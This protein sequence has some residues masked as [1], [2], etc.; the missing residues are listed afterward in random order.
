MSLNIETATQKAKEDLAK[1]LEI[2]ADDIKTSSVEEKEFSDMSLGATVGDE[3]AAQ[4]IS[5]GWSI[6][7][8]ANDKDYEYRGDKYQL[9]LV[10]FDGE[11][12]MIESL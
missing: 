11:N 10:D 7:L 4:M 5:N 8:N 6:N 3:F 12:Y 1:R 2:T 9:R